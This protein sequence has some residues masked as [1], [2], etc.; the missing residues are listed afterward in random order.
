MQLSARQQ[1]FTMPFWEKLTPAK[2]CFEDA[3]CGAAIGV[4]QLHRNAASALAA[5]T[6][7]RKVPH[8]TS[9]GMPQ[10]TSSAP[11]LRVEN[12]I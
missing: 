1:T 11:K 4:L 8:L 3:Y 2:D 5:G 6:K 7:V 10:R 9:P 12:L